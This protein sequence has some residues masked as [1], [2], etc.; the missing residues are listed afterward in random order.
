MATLGKVLV[1][2][3]GIGG[4]S[5][6]LSL[7]QRGIDVEVVELRED[8]K[9]YHVGIV[10]QG[11]FIR[12]MA[13]LGVA[14]A[15]V[16]A[17]FP[18]EGVKV[19]D[20]AGN[21]KAEFP[22]MN[23]GG[24]GLPGD[25][26][27]TRPA[28]HKVL[29]DAVTQ[30]GI[31]VRL[32][33]T[34]RQVVDRGEHVDVEFSD[35]SKAAYGLVIAADGAYSGLRR[36]LFGDRY[37]PTFTGQGV[38][39]YNIRRP[40]DMHWSHIHKGRPGGTA[41]FMPLTEDTMYVF[42]VGAESGNPH[43]PEATLADELRRRLEGYGGQIPAIRDQIVDPSLVV[44]RPLEPAIVKERWF[45]G[46]VALL[47]DS[48]HSATPHMGQGAAMAVEDAVVIGEELAKDRDVP[49]A[50]ERY[51]QRRYDRVMFVGGSSIQLGEWEQ[52]PTPD[53]NPVALMQKVLQRVAEPI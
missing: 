17:G 2:G 46:R 48:A 42:Y 33:V 39:R 49:A 40:K 52:R 53:A 24:P 20:V 38:W 19:L 15:A 4:L 41:G 30:R 37:T 36:Q 14:E 47:G 43:F 16:A 1:V 26:G 3:G 21:V 7:K 29:T 27:L 9:V 28:L 12:A 5:A 22:S 23:I 34:C 8:W 18:V 51:W 50:L 13:A 10:V 31:P 44:Y 45:K 32:G 6:A 11:N 25:L 35:D